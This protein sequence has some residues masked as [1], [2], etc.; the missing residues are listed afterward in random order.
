[1]GW[2]TTKQRFVSPYMG[3]KKLLKHYIDL[4]DKRS[5]VQGVLLYSSNPEALWADFSSCFT[6]LEAAGGYVE[7][8]KGTLL[9]FFRRGMWDMPKGKIDPG[10]TPEIAAVREVK[11]ETG[12]QTVHR[13]AFLM[14]TWHTYTQKDQRI[15]K[16][17]WWYR[18]TTPDTQVTPQ[19]E[20]DIEEIRW[21]EP[22]GWLQQKP[23]VYQSIRD[24][25]EKAMYADK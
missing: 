17:T 3:K 14:H 19:T 12:L 13:G 10:E 2:Q 24:V 15:L 7:N 16:K 11:E 1:M 23:A 22:A 8:A 21:V 9:V 5:D 6:L 18:M 25:M 4:L 20:E